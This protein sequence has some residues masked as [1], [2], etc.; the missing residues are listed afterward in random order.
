[1]VWNKK[2]K[3]LPN[4]TNM[5]HEI[6]EPLLTRYHVRTTIGFYKKIIRL[7][8]SNKLPKAKDMYDLIPN[9]AHFN[10]DNSSDWFPAKFNK[11][12][13][14]YD[15]NTPNPT[16]SLTPTKHPENP[17]AI[18]RQLKKAGLNLKRLKNH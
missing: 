7:Y 4:R 12:M 6:P 18:A 8:Q 10:G 5:N 9:K 3:T 13:F 16:K 2:R 17:Y 11:Q 1:M 15:L 14:Y